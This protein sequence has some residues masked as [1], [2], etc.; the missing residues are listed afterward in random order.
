MHS[1]S[2]SR[3]RLAKGHPYKL[4]FRERTTLVPPPAK[5]R[6][7]TDLLGFNSMVAVWLIVIVLVRYPYPGW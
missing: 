6:R 1:P 4:A 3:P 5:P 7:R 2:Q